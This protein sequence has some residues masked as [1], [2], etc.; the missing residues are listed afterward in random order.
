MTVEL[1]R[2]KKPVGDFLLEMRGRRKQKN[3]RSFGEERGEV[4]FMS[5]V[6][7]IL[8]IMTLE[9]AIKF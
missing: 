6:V 8:V 2:T 1:G 7:L 5:F 4:A 3:P 9:P